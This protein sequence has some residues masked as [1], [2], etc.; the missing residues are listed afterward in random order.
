M[1]AALTGAAGKGS[2]GATGRSE[3]LT[4]LLARAERAPRAFASAAQDMS[5]SGSDVHGETRGNT[6]PQ[7]LGAVQQG[8]ESQ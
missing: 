5:A 2:R 6:N 8:N 7:S 3:S 4:G 1:L